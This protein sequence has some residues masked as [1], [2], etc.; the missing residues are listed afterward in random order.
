MVLHV[1]T[2]AGQRLQNGR[3]W[4]WLVGKISSFI[5]QCFRLLYTSFHEVQLSSCLCYP[6]GHK[7]CMIA[8]HAGLR[9]LHKR[10]HP[11]GGC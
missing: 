11:P 2:I 10:C 1:I 7:V 6:E 8:S 4:S 9:G 5:C 3:R